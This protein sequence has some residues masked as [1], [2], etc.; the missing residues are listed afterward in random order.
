M[1]FF[2]NVTASAV[3]IGDRVEYFGSKSE[4]PSYGTVISIIQDLNDQEVSNRLI[5]ERHLSIKKRNNNG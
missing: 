5:Q 4:I 3:R 2:V 1:L